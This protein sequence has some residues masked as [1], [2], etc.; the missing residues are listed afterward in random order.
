MDDDDEA[1]T[2]AT[3]TIRNRE[4]LY[5]ITVINIILVLMANA[6]GAARVV[7][8]RCLCSIRWIQFHFSPSVHLPCCHFYG[9]RK[10]P[11]PDRQ[12]Y[13][14]SH[15]NLAKY[16]R[17]FQLLVIVAQWENPPLDN[18]KTDEIIIT[19]TG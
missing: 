3:R 18:S 13:V 14:Y 9:S 4:S 19:H 6:N 10:Q 15:L 2:S 11:N 17:V 16:K 5:T 1:G 12:V 7:K 8:R